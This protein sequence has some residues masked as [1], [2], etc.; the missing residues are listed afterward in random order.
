MLLNMSLQIR[1]DMPSC[2]YCIFNSTNCLYILV[3]RCSSIEKFIVRLVYEYRMLTQSVQSLI[4]V[5]KYY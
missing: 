3:L 2:K 4:K 5:K 1:Y